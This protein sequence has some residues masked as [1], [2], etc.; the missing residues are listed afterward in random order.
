[1]K[2]NKGGKVLT[3]KQKLEFIKNRPLK[4]TKKGTKKGNAK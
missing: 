2:S 3:D 1:M 4:T